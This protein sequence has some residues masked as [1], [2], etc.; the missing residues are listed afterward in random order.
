MGR[1]FTYK[2]RRYYSSK[3]DALNARRKGDRIYYDPHLKAYYIVR[4]NKGSFW[5]F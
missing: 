3:S 4:P 1:I 2:G 5:G